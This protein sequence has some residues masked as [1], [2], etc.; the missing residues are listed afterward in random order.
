MRVI[1]EGFV[2]L[3]EI[4]DQP[5]HFWYTKNGEFYIRKYDAD[6]LFVQI[7]TKYALS[8]KRD[9]TGGDE[10]TLPDSVCR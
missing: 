6:T 10:Q 7:K 1:Y 4:A 3:K 5:T 8:L 2:P 9:E